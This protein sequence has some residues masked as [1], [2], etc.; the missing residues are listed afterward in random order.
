[1]PSPFALLGGERKVSALKEY[2]K[3]ISAGAVAA[4]FGIAI[5]TVVSS[6]YFPSAGASQTTTCSVSDIYRPLPPNL[7]K[8]API[9]EYTYLIVYNTTNGAIL[10]GQVELSCQ[11]GGRLPPG[12]FES[13]PP[14]P[15]QVLIPERNAAWL[16]VTADPNLHAMEVNG[17]SNAFYVNLQSKQLTLFPGVTF[18]SNYT[19]AFYNGEP[20]TN[21]TRLPPA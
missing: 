3:E 6:Y 10:S 12:P 21:G 2:K 18:N 15:N 5:L 19:Q 16:N 7:F 8:D 11:L 13:M 9:P 17:Y 14:G 4:V 1:M 20:I